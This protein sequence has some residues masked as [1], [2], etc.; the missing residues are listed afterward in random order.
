MYLGYKRSYYIIFR[1]L[2]E[3]IRFLIMFCFKL[4]YNLCVIFW[5]SH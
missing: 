3:K 1:G 2:Q 4:A 5:K